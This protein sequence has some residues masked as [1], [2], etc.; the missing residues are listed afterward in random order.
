MQEQRELIG[1]LETDL[2]RVRPY[3]PVR[4]EGEGQD[5]SSAADIIS[6][7]VRGAERPKRQQSEEDTAASSAASLL[8]IVSSQRERFKQRNT[9]LEAVSLSLGAP[10]VFKTTPPTRSAVSRS[11]T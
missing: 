9:E 4:T 6:E 11:R 3:L 5:S 10:P 8:P 2:S 7:A 1:Q